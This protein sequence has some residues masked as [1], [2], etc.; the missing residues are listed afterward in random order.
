VHQAQAITINGMESLHLKCE[1]PG[2]IEDEAG[3]GFWAEAMECS[4]FN[5]QVCMG[6]EGGKEKCTWCESDTTDKEPGHS[7]L[8]QS[9]IMGRAQRKATFRCRRIHQ[10][11]SSLFVSK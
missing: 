9:D 7:V 1:P 8:Y 6:G 10:Y 2:P 11:R 3:I 4:K 5:L